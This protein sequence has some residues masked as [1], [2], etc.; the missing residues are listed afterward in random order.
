VVVAGRFTRRLQSR[1]DFIAG[2]IGCN[3]RRCVPA[4]RYP[5]HLWSTPVSTAFTVR[6]APENGAPR[7]YPISLA[8]ARKHAV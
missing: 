4:L 3:H 7:D 1:A 8:V 2:L 5:K 6:K